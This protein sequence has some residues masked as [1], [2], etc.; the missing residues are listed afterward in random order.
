MSN[1]LGAIFSILLIFIAFVIGVDLVIMQ[2]NYTNLDAL[3][4]S[5]SYKIANTGYLNEETILEYQNT[6]KITLTPI[7]DVED[8]Q[9]GTVYPY[10]ISKTYQ[11]IA[12]SITEIEISIVRYA[13]IN[14]YK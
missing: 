12:I 3:S 6:Y 11:P 9:E 8:N 13:I 7:N 2:L 4:T 5:I 14:F 10:K 1:K